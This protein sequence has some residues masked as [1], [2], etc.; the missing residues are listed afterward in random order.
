MLYFYRN[1][2]VFICIYPLRGLGAYDLKS[3]LL[4]GEIKE[5]RFQK[6][7]RVSIG[8]TSIWKLNISCQYLHFAN[9]ED[10]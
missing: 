7:L 5:R 2:P 10:I 4:W 9:T 3:L 6:K 8:G 1:D